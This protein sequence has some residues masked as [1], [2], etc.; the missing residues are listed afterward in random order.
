MTYCYK[1]TLY[2]FFL[3]SGSTGLGDSPI[4][5]VIFI[6]LC[7]RLPSLSR[8]FPTFLNSF[9]ISWTYF[10]VTCILLFWLH[11]RP[12]K[13]H[14]CLDKSSNFIKLSAFLQILHWP[15][16]NE[17]TCLIRRV[18]ELN[19]VRGSSFFRSCYFR[20]CLLY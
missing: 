5:G 7:P 17:T 8:R 16:N 6:F 14:S 13:W 11:D 3:T 19:V 4:P 9:Q 12:I 18:M 2:N 10:S 15:S 20:K 1:L